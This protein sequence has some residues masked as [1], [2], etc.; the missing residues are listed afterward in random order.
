MLKLSDLLEL[1]CECHSGGNGDA[2]ALDSGGSVPRLVLMVDASEAHAWIKPLRKLSTASHFVALQ[3]FRLSRDVARNPQRLG[4]L[5]MGDFTHEW[6]LSNSL[7]GGNAA[8]VAARACSEDVS[9][10]GW[11]NWA[12]KGRGLLAEYAVSRRWTDFAFRL[13]T[14]A[15]TAQHWRDNFPRCTLPLLR[16]VTLCQKRP[17]RASGDGGGATP[18]AAL[19]DLF[20]VAGRLRRCLKRLR[21][22]WLPPPQLDTG[23][24]FRLIRSVRT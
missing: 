19:L 8:Q 21:M 1:W 5:R 13:P 17:D 15:D 10:A 6:V 9:H 20:C 3:T 22:S 14:G 16:L 7:A 11:V 2:S 24:G 23:H 12:D 18:G 4:Q